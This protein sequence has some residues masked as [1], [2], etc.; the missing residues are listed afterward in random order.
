[1]T[2][3]YSLPNSTTMFFVPCPPALPG[4]H[5]ALI[6]RSGEQVPSLRVTPPLV[7]LRGDSEEWDCPQGAGALP[8][9]LDCLQFPD[10]LDKAATSGCQ[11]LLFFP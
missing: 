6:T 5:I 4:L 7:C 11:A 9:T 1:M 8:E 10:V 3:T 2:F